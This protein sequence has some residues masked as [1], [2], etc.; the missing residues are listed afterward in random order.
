[1][2]VISRFL[3]IVVAM[4]WNDHSPPHFHAKYGEYEIVVSIQD[5]SNDMFLHVREATYVKDYE[6]DVLF[7]DGR[8]GTADLSDSLRGPVFEPLKD[9]VFFARLEVDPELKT[10]VWPNGA[11]V[12]PE[13]LY[14]LA[15]SNEPELQERFREWGYLV[16]AEA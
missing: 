1:M 13:Y 15:F 12:A 16:P 9:K 5:G 10:V 4:Y 8:R 6:V 2:P 11:D 3:G 7:D 14:F